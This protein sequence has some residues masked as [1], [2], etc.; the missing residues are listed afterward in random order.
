MC[1]AGGRGKCGRHGEHLGSGG[2]Q[3]AKQLRKADVITHGQPDT[4]DWC[5]DYF[6]SRARR[7]VR[8]LTVAFIA[9]RDVYIEQVDLV[10]ARCASTVG[11]IHQRSGGNTAIRARTQRHR[12]AH[13]PGAQP[14]GGPGQELLNRA[15][16]IGFSDRAFVGVPESH[17]R[18]VLG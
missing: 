5:I 18:K 7:H 16:A 8:R 6:G 1:T 9:R 4:A 2:A 14:D 3:S 11:A 10:V 15:G 12:A 17:E 13:D